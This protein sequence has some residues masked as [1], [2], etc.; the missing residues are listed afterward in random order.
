MILEAVWIALATMFA[1][2][3]RTLLTVLGNIVAVAALVLVVAFTQGMNREITRAILARG[4][5]TFTVERTGPIH[6]DE[7]WERVKDRPPVTL[8]DVE[9]VR[10]DATLAGHVLAQ[11]NLDL[12]IR[13]AKRSVERAQVEARSGEYVYFLGEAVAVGRHFT[14]AEERRG[15]PVVLLGSDLAETLFPG[16]TAVGRTVRIAGR[17]FDV[18]GV[19]EPRGAI[20]GQSQDKYAMLPLG[21]ALAEWG[22]PW[23][24]DLVVKPERPELLDVCADEVRAVLRARRGLRPLQEDPFELLAAA[25]Y[26]KMY[27]DSSRAVYGALIGLVALAL[28]VGGIV[29]ANVMLMVVAQRTREIGIRKAVGARRTHILLQFLVE[30]ATL[31]LVGGLLGFGIGAAVTGAAAALTPISFSIEAWSVAVGWGMV[32]V[33]AVL[34][35][36]YPA[37]RAARLDPIVA[38]RHER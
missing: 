19:M 31:S 1:N 22:R 12:P 8:A 27:R 36:L 25:T 15:V 33:V 16:E 4:A 34:A 21:A 2:K 24:V 3:L 38:L 11:W 17:H 28:F 9:A 18:I 26:L 37:A 5:D 7:E 30:A 20:L 13:T 14:P 10:R 32:L 29:I 35:G 23:E 6:S